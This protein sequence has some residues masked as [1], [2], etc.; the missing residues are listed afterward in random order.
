[1]PTTNQI[2]IDLIKKYGES[3]KSQAALLKSYNKRLI[4]EYKKS[5]KRINN[6]ISKLYA[7]M[8]GKPTLDKARRYDRLNKMYNKIANELKQLGI[9]EY[10]ID[11]NALKDTMKNSYYRSMYSF[12]SSFNTG[13]SFDILSAETINASLLNPLTKVKWPN[14]IKTNINNLNLRLQSEIN[15]SIIR[16]LS[17]R[18]T[19]KAVENIIVKTKGADVTGA[20]NK[21]LRI[22]RT[23]THRIYNAGAD[24][25]FNHA[26]EAGN[27][28]GIKP[29]RK[30]WLATFDDRTRT[31]HRD[32]D[33]QLSNKQGEFEL[34]GVTFDS[35]GNSGLAEE[36]INCRCSY[37]TV[38]PGV[39]NRK[40]FDNIKKKPINDITYKEWT[41]N[42]RKLAS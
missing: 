1:M 17:Y 7:S 14:S 5:L 33:G 42:G 25:G 22:V 6:D 11:Q 12:E 37:R 28:L 23:E 32:A 38:V 36:D 4:N 3:E 34:F 41:K 21:A 30:L 19:A 2:N 26:Q 18:D 40:R 13:I 24:L 27:K 39:K 29:L 31:N 8:E 10:K 15:Q 9:N 16:G 20:V 35:P